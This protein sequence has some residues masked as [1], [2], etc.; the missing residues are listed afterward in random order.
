MNLV[1]ICDT[2]GWAHRPEGIRAADVTDVPPGGSLADLPLGQSSDDPIAEMIRL[3]CAGEVDGFFLALPNLPSD[4]VPGVVRRFAEAGFRGVTVDALKRTVAVEEILK[5][6]KTVADAGMVHL[7][8]CGATPGLLTAAAAL[9][10]QSYQTVEDVTIEFG[11]G[12]SNWETYRATVREDIAH[13][14]DMDFAKAQAMSDADVESF[15]DARSGILELHDMEHADDIM[16]ERAGVVARDRVHV[17]G[18]VDTRQAKKPV[19]TSLRL[20]GTTFEGKRSTHTFTLGDETSMAANVNGPA[21]GYL[22]AGLWLRD[23][24]IGGVFTSADV[25]P[26]FVR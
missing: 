21:L 17:G 15:L 25:M 22:K 11:V 3:G 10:A 18:I 23:R 24:G 2:R 6:D 14:R 13:Q 19:S 7:T 8:G 26:R 9:A 12:I 20:T 1:A 5:L 4:F 16:L